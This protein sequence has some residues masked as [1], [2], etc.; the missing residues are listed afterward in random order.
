[1]RHP[2]LGYLTLVV[3]AWPAVA[4]ADVV[5]NPLFV[6]HAVLQQGTPVPVWGTADPGE[7][8]TVK[9][10]PQVVKTSAGAEG[11]WSLR[12]APL[13]AGGPYTLTI[14]GRNEIVLRDV[15]VGEVW[16][17]GG[18]SNMERQLGP[19]VGQ[20]PIADWEREAAAANHPQIRHFGV[21]QVKSLAP[22]ETVKGQWEVC[23]P[24]TVKQFTAVGYFFARDLH[25]ARKVPIGLIHASWGGTPAE[26]WMRPA[27]LLPLSDFAETPA[28]LAELATDPDG[29]R[30]KHEARLETWFA[31]VDPGSAAGRSWN[32]PALDTTAWKT[33]TVPGLWEE[34]GEPELNGV[35]WLRRTF[36]LPPSAAGLFGEL[37]LGKV[38]DVDTTWLNG[39]KIGAT[40][41]YDLERRY[42]IPP[43]VLEAGRNVLAVRVLDTGGGGG[44]WGDQPIG[45]H[46]RRG[47]AP[48]AVE[49]SG[50]W[51]YRVGA[52]LKNVPA[53]PVSVTGDADTPTVLWNGMIAPLV[54]Y[55]MRGVIWYQGE[56]N[57]DRA[58][59]YR[60][61]LPALISD[62]RQAWG[63][64]EFPFLF[65]Q[66]AP[67]QDMS[68]E[69]REAQ[70]LAWQGTSNT[71]MV[72][73][74]DCGD[75]RDIHPPR[76]QP[77]GAR[78][79]LAARAL[80]HGEA[81]AY[82][83]PVFAG[84]KLAGGKAMLRFD[85][86]GGGLVAKGGPLTGFT[87]AGAD[88][89]FHPAVAQIRGATVVVSSRRVS[90][91]VAVRYGWAAVP[92]GNLANQA[93]LPASPFRTDVD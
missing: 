92:S 85:H 32:A 30:R 63:Q 28:Q 1:M 56:S 38:D 49:L 8:V 62:W 88:R 60:T 25:A 16:L 55:A 64:G 50:P 10:G 21:A 45:L 83:G 36:E 80:A 76:K 35:V 44:I 20:Q 53:P 86:V 18:Q 19:R 33:M 65:V 82:S 70:L 66:I 24:E 87:I 59:Q 43:G 77:V 2:C 75:A 57:V 52:Q 7:P 41:G 11:K 74:T 91:P 31:A 9:I 78:L 69:L 12:L 58:R 42:R 14:A 26:A 51:Q 46:V 54:P 40:T 4:L 93:G 68:P 47:R 29:A 3:A 22:R 17:C 6:D 39:V 84:I 73:T 67:H 89:I 5:P 27:G 48:L 90:R 37:H 81:I 79:A 71:A 34:A 72:V 15:L 61:L 13:A 23:S